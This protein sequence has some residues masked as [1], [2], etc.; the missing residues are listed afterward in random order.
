M[1]AGRVVIVEFDVRA[2]PLVRAALVVRLPFTK[3]QLLVLLA[4]AV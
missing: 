4:V 1:P 2:I 3:S